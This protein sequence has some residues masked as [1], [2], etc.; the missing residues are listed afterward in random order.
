MTMLPAH[1]QPEPLIGIDPLAFATAIY[2]KRF[3]ILK[4]A[5]L[6]ALTG[7]VL[8]IIFGGSLH[9]EGLVRIEPEVSTSGEQTSIDTEMDIIRSYATL[10][11]TAQHMQRLVHVRPVQSKALSR[12]VFL[13]HNGFAY[14]GLAEAKPDEAAVPMPAITHFVIENPLHNTLNEWFTLSIETQDGF[15]LYRQDGSL[16]AEGRLDNPISL[17]LGDSANAPTLHAIISA[18]TARPGHRFVLEPQSAERQALQ[19]EGGLDI[20]RKGFRERSGLLQVSYGNGDA[21]FA[22]QFLAALM[23]NYTSNAY[24]R[25]A[26]GKLQ[27]LKNLRSEA[28]RL[29]QAVGEAEQT[30]KEFKEKNALID[31]T[32]KSAALFAQ[33][34]QVEEEMREIDN[35]KRELDVTYTAGHPVMQAITSQL[36]IA[37]QRAA[38]LERQ[39]SILPETERQLLLLQREADIT[40]QILDAN[41]TAMAD[42]QAEVE[43]ITGYARVVSPPQP[44]GPGLMKQAA[45]LVAIGAYAGR[46]NGGCVQHH[47]DASRLLH[48]C[49]SVSM[50]KTQP[51][52]RSLPLSRIKIPPLPGGVRAGMRSFLRRRHYHGCSGQNTPSPSLNRTR[53]ICCITGMI[54]FLPLPALK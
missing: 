38:D 21:V 13:L 16:L 1:S 32:Q 8:F 51:A 6:G 52:C 39:M 7:L 35:K 45:I 50:L 12:S 18:G 30:V 3:H 49:A 14:L 9:Y 2:A 4:M 10:E 11:N 19:V 33:I 15:R 23:Q 29:R 24:D 22:K 36:A 42:L 47:D 27:A 28:V 46:I 53:C 37:Q 48:G 43:H 54:G 26:L 44:G 40:K 31:L 20:L 17:A 34:V 25:S 5:A 41:I